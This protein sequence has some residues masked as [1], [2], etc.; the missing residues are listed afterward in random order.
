MPPVRC[1]R[2]DAENDE[3]ARRGGIKLNQCNVGQYSATGYG[4]IVSRVQLAAIQ[5]VEIGAKGAMVKVVD[6]LPTAHTPPGSLTPRPRNAGDFVHKGE[7]H[8]SKTALSAGAM[9]PN[10]DKTAV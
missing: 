9:V 4:P 7:E 10:G 2:G 3:L 5:I 8:F 6:L 1:L